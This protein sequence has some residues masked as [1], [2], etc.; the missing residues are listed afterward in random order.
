VAALVT[1]EV[2]LD[3]VPGRLAAMTEYETEGIEVVTEF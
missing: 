2:A 1:R 3:D